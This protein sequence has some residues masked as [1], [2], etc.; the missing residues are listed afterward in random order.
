MTTVWLI[1]ATLLL[2]LLAGVFAAADSALMS[3]S[4]ARVEA[5]VR[6]GRAG[7]SALSAVVADRPRH[8]NL[9]MLLRVTC[10]T[11]AVILLAIALAPLFSAP[12]IG[13]VLTA[14]IMVLA[15][16]ILVGVGP[17][18]LGRQHP[19]RIGLL[20]AA[21]IRV[22]GTVLSPLAKLLILLGN[23]ITPG[24]GFRDGPFSTEVEL[25]ELVDMASNRGVVD[26]GERKMI[27]SVFELGETP[28]REIMVPR[29]DVVWAERD[30]PVD[31]VL[32]LAL[33][34]GY[35]RIPVLG[36]GIDDVIGVAY[37]KDLVRARDD[38]Q[39]RGAPQKSLPE[40]L[41]P[42]AFVP[43]SKRSDELMREMQRTRNHMAVVVDEYGGTAGV[44]TIEDILEEIVGEI[45]D[46]YDTEEI[47]EVAEV[48]DGAFRVA[49]RVPV[50]DLEELFAGRF[51]GTPRED[52]LRRALETADVD[53]VGGLLAQRLG[54]VPLPGAVADVEGLL[55]LE[56]EGGKDSRGRIRITSVLVSPLEPVDTDGDEADP[57]RTDSA[58]T[59]DGPDPAAGDPTEPAEHSGAVRADRA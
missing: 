56:G 10:E 58:R 33:K 57:A 3:I 14:V 16:Y 36:E 5:V 22:L 59:D 47:P 13:L 2:V 49:S 52:E 29:P 45:T 6:S 4:R 26:E 28:V 12:W 35:S 9:L 27:H 20:L 41:R 50:E 25:R 39:F 48:D 44:V 42:A 34:S 17:R 32:R 46:E 53:T 55:R 18:T 40:I 38:A 43:D 21:P 37:L 1:V 51:R 30:T 19:Y 8:V 15:S 31:K 23:A 54:K 7:G 24:P 11:V